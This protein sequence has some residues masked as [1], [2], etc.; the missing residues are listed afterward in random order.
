M[1][2]PKFI[3][4]EVYSDRMT[5]HRKPKRSDAQARRE[6]I[7]GAAEDVFARLGPD[8]PLDEICKASGVGRA[9]LYR[10]YPNRAALA[11]GLFERNMVRL[12]ES[13][14]SLS[15]DPDSLFLLLEQVLDIKVKSSSL[16]L[17]HKDKRGYDPELRRRF[18]DLVEIALSRAK[19]VGRV[20]P[21]SDIRNDRAC[22]R[23]DGGSLELQDLR[24]APS[25]K[26]RC[27]SHLP[28]RYPPA[29]RHALM[30]PPH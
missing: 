5:V 6:I 9:T 14:A 3:I 29:Q 21:D 17:A 22:L 27:A 10:N 13:A 4:G 7:L 18:R 15:G 30:A 23:Y 8:A 20:R 1:R 19:T 25:D 28:G 12:E 2:L 26:G 16:Y 11:E 24:G